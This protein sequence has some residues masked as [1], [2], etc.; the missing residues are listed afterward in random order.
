MDPLL[1]GAVQQDSLQG[2]CPAASGMRAMR[3]QK[4]AGDQAPAS[5]TVDG[6]YSPPSSSE[7]NGVARSRIF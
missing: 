5:F 7:E 3:E 2:V 1:Q 6:F 4:K